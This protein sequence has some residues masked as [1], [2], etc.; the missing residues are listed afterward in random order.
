MVVIGAPLA[1]AADS[2]HANSEQLSAV[3]SDVCAKV[4]DRPVR[5]PG[6]ARP[7]PRV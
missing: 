5:Q 2:F 7:G 1:I 3:L 4:H 6:T